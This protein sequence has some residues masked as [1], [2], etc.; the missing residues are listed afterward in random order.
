MTLS[1]RSRIRVARIID[2]PGEAICFSFDGAIVLEDE[3][4]KAVNN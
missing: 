1:D 3:N 2:G 4:L